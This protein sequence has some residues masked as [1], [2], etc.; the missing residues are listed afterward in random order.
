MN[1]YIKYLIIAIIGF[2]FGILINL[3][4]CNTQQS[5]I[6][7]IPIH[8]TITITK[9]E[10]KEKTKVIYK[11]DTIIKI[12]SL[13]IDNDSIVLPIEY[14]QYKNRIVTDSTKTDLQIDYHGAYSNIDKVR[15]INNY[16]NKKETIVQKPKKIGLTWCIGPSIGFSGICDVSNKK[17]GYG[18]TIGI[19]ATVGIGGIIK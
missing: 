1:Q 6:E 3:P 18:P 7:Y 19:T 12:D 15:I 13:I 4:S 5:K 10:I 14:K 8:D 9:E 2:I 11:K 16:F 17:F